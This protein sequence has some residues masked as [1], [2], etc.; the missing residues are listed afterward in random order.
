VSL[1]LGEA[2][3]Y[4]GVSV[5]AFRRTASE[6][7]KWSPALAGWL[8]THV[9]AFDVVDVHAVFSHSSLAAAQACR[10]AD[11]PYVV[12]PHGALDPWS[13]R[14]KR[15]QK[16]LVMAVGA[17]A[18]LRG[19]RAI[20]YT[21]DAER[22]LA[23]KELPW[24]PAGAIVP[25][26]VDDRRFEV[27]CT[28]ESPPAVL[29]L[30]RL[31]PKKGLEQLIEAFHVVTGRGPLSTWRLTIAGDGDPRYVGRLRNL[32]G[33]G[34]AAGRI[35]FAG[36]VSGGEQDRL[37]AASTLIASPSAQENFGLSLMEAMA[38][39]LPALVTPG[40]NLASDVEAARA[41]WVV[42]SE[43]D[44]FADALGAILSDRDDLRRRGAAARAL[45]SGYRW[46]NSTAHLLALYD[47]VRRRGGQ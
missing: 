24:L 9:A 29:T 35:R 19:A 4:G 44:A 42:P 13:L 25:L 22:R 5:M 17:R 21:T 20:Q 15:W 1:P 41:G 33:R 38:A 27:V 23:E 36:W 7:F 10:R 39:G 28:H 12:R 16:R 26:A 18:M 40:V 2:T 34:P 11:V 3:D 32:A 30:S 47:T 43:P 8:K 31:D 45:A 14:R 46:T 37:I 6:A